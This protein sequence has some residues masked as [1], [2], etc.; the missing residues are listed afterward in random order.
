[1][2]S[3]FDQADVSYQVGIP[4]SQAK[5]G[6]YTPVFYKGALVIVDEVDCIMYENP[7]MFHAFIQGNCCV[8]F[9]ATP[10]DGEADTIEATILKHM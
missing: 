2:W 6:Q 3:Y 8:A 5:D 7:S 9:T 4:T 1:M 10:D